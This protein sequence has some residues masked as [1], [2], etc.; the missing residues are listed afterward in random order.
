MVA[1]RSRWSEWQPP[2]MPM[3]R[4]DKTDKSPS[5]SF[6]SSLDRRFESNSSANDSISFEA[7]IIRW[8]IANPPSD[9][10]PD[11]CI[12]CK[13]Q[14]GRPGEDGVPVL[15]GEDRHVWVHHHCHPKWMARRRREAAAALAA[16]GIEL[17]RPTLPDSRFEQRHQSYGR[18]EYRLRTRQLLANLA[19]K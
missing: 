4:T 3:S 19:K 17:R 1:F 2:Q 9:L 8:L 14:L 7:T 11:I 13:S 10:G 5:V 18:V 6:V 15:V 12:D 16:I